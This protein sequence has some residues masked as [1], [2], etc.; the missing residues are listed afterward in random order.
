MNGTYYQNPTFPGNNVNDS[1]TSSEITKQN[2]PYYLSVDNLIKYNKGKKV[3][4]FVLFP[5]NTG[6]EYDGII[7]T[8][9]TDFIIIQD[10]INNSWLLIKKQYINYIEFNEP[11]IYECSD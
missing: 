3:K 6:K 2:Q 9:G 7:D 10:K 4:I 11:I 1:N 8:I 5:N